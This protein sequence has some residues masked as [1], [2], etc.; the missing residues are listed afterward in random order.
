M[1]ILFLYPRMAALSLA[2][3]N[4]P[5]TSVLNLASFMKREGHAVCIYD[6]DTNAKDVSQVM[7]EFTPDVVACT[8]M[9]ALQ[10]ADMRALCREVR[11]LRPDAPILCGGLMASYIPEVI[12]QEGLADY[13]GIGEGEYTLLE[14][15]EVIGGRR[16]PSTVQ[17][18]V[19]LD[20]EGQAVHTPL[21]PFADLSDFP[22]T[23]FSLLPVEKYFSYYPEAPHTL[24][25]HASKGCPS[26]CTFCYNPA[27][28]RCQYRA[29]ARQS[30]MREI[31]TLVSDFGADGIFFVDELWGVDKE[32][33]RG[34]CSGI[35]ALSEKLQK[36]IRWTCETRIGVLSFEDMK[37]MADSGCWMLMFGVES[38]SPEVLRRMKKGYPLARVVSDIENCKKAGISVMTF[39]IFGFP[40]ETPE[41]LKQT[42]HTIFRLNPAICAS[43]L[44]CPMP[45]S[46][47]YNTLVSSGKLEPP[48]G[49]EDWQWLTERRLMKANYSAIA[50]RELKVV[51]HFFYWRAL[52]QKRRDQKTGRLDVIKIGLR[53][54]VDD[55]GRK[56]FFHFFF[57]NV[58][59]A[60]TSAWYTYAYPG[61]RKKYDLYARSYGRKDWDDLGHLDPK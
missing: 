6:R 44:F 25:V 9:F 42:V 41:Q 50:N 31:E 40:C 56:G 16:D 15:L 49:L 54:V 21:R 18:L 46:A 22:D 20:R 8:L 10:A 37:L 51:Q 12:L 5:P 11:S 24:P 39:F 35:A 34:Y 7:E 4:M 38:G 27:Y 28:H 3:G 59:L 14:L 48:Q 13:V 32:E 19:Y 1:R 45:G 52:F 60:L 36:P 33:L 43:G 2:V 30:V 57:N 26:Q 47:E 58:R 53:R 61:I 55:I 23:D 17:S 29:R